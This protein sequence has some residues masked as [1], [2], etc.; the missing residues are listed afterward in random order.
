MYY[1]YTVQIPLVKGKTIT[2]KK[3]DTKYIL[4]QYGQK[5]IA[6]KKY[7]IPQRVIVG[8]ALIDDEKKMYPNENFYEY[9]PNSVDELPEAY[10]SCALKIGSYVVIQKLFREY[11]LD[12]L[13]SEWFPRDYGLLLDLVSYLIVN[14]ENA[15]QYYPDFAFNHP[16]FSENMRIYS[17][18]KV[19]RMLNSV[20]QEQIIGFLN[21]WNKNRDHKQRIYISYDSTNKN[22]QA[23]DIDIIEY[24][25][26]KDEK[27][28][29]IFNLAL[30]FDKSNRVPL[31]YD[32]DSQ[33]VC[34]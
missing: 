11:K 30:I 26:A 29:P 21:D 15:G 7:A 2:K 28:L 24:G 27:G 32:V 4:Y 19:S 10:R 33:F 8:K 22:C 3:G 17:D 25:K 34:S 18:S 23:G 14:E 1:D 5:Y 16:L 13:L 12:Q 31:F 20:T 9:F 6:E